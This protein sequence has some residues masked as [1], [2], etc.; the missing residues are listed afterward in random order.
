MYEYAALI[1]SISLTILLCAWREAAT[2]NGRD[3][4]LMGAVGLVGGVG[5]LAVATL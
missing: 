3:A 5:A 4:G 2:G 1:A